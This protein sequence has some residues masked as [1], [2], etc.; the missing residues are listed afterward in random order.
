L[1]HI[2]LL[3]AGVPEPELEDMARRQVA[4]TDLLRANAVFTSQLFR[5][6][7]HDPWTLVGSCVGLLVVAVIACWIPARRASRVDPVRALRV[8]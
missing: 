1:Y 6:S 3:P 7:P 4:A 5:V 2:N 8:E